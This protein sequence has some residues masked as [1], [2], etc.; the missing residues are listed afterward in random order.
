MRPYMHAFV[1]GAWYTT[2]HTVAIVLNC[3]LVAVCSLNGSQ[4]VADTVLSRVKGVVSCNATKSM[5][6]ETRVLNHART[7]VH[8]LRVQF[9][10][11]Q[12][13]SMFSPL[14]TT[15]CAA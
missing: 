5:S 2:L 15:D 14:I 9:T 1:E 4:V 13:K 3:K 11:S 7:H 8:S 12:F 10:F 6:V